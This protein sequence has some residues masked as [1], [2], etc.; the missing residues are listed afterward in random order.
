MKKHKHNFSLLN[1][2]QNIIKNTRKTVKN[3]REIKIV[4]VD[5]SHSLLKTAK[6][7]ISFNHK[8]DEDDSI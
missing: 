5:K 1:E 7:K 2:T 4:K 3:V 8:K 6:E